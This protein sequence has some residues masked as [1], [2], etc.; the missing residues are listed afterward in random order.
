MTD[1]KKSKINY[2][3]DDIE[4]ESESESYDDIG[5]EKLTPSKGDNETNKSKRDEYKMKML[6]RI[7]RNDD[8]KEKNNEK[9]NNY[10]PDENYTKKININK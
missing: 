1:T 5:L 6:F 3:N 8:Y 10:N 2:K 9:K 4:S 7:I